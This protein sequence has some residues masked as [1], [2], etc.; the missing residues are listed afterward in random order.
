MARLGEIMVPWLKELHGVCVMASNQTSKNFQRHLR[1]KRGS[2][3]ILAKDEYE[4]H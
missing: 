2:I 1:R 4:M 3:A